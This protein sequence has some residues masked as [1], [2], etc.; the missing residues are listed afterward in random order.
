MPLY[1]RFTSR[2]SST[3]DGTSMIP[4]QLYYFASLPEMVAT[5]D[6]VITG[7]VQTTEPGR[8]MGEGDGAIQFV[9]VTVI[10]NR[11]LFGEIDS[12]TVVLEESGLEHGHPSQ[13]DDLGVYF[14]HQKADAPQFF[15]LVNSQ[16]RFL[17]DT[18]GKL[19]ALDDGVAWAKAI[20]LLSLAELESLIE[21]AAGEVA[22]GKV[23]PA[24]PNF[25]G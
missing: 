12:S 14:L 13:V 23:A 1:D 21:A 10:V 11:V 19:V 8:V 18:N 24:K 20:E 22:K 6:L 7:T 15:R 2:R 17:D 5:S 4:I 25:P 3:I 9:E 16:G